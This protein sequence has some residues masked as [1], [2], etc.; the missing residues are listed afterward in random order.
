MDNGR[1]S[2]AILYSVLHD[3]AGTAVPSKH[4]H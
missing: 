2:T 1:R 3:F 4:E